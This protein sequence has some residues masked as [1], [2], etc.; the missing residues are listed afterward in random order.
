MTQTLL[1]NFKLLSKWLF[2]VLRLELQQ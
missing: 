1:H 2:C